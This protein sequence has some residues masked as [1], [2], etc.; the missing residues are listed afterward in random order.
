VTGD[1]STPVPPRGQKRK[2]QVGPTSR[3]AAS[4]ATR[5]S[6]NRR[7]A[8]ARQRQH[9]QKIMALLA[10]GVVVLVVGVLVIVK[11][12]S[13]SSSSKPAA[14]S[15]LSS[16]LYDELTSPSL[17]AL[18]AAA[19]NYHHS[20]LVY[21]SKITS[22]SLS[23]KGKPEV[24]YLGAEYCPYCATERW[25]MVLALSKFGTF[26]GLREIRSNTQDAGI[27]H[28]ATLTFAD[29]TYTSKYL[30][31][32]P[33]EMENTVGQTLV[34]PT[35]AQ[36]ALLNKYTSGDIPFVDLDGKSAIVG[37][38]YDPHLLAGLDQTQVIDQLGAGTSTL[39]S[40]IEAD[41]GAII[42]NLCPLTGSSPAGVC[43]SFPKP[44]QSPASAGV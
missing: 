22:S 11:V 21:P 43:S 27:E 40:N 20:D 17:A 29:A 6:A 23:E 19:E 37:A 24:L 41:A 4:K 26:H 34:T 7:A 25:A 3:S 9:R 13:G 28:L 35:K 36:E 31:F 8:I 10:I 1:D 14:A 15:V 39:A 38:E 42:S 30:A 16:A 2:R 44:L 18:S 32:K 33:I 12:S 5:A